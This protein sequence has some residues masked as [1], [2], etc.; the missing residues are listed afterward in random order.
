MEGSAGLAFRY[1]HRYVLT[2]SHPI[3]IVGAGVAGL[4]LAREL[5]QLGHHPV[6]LERSQGIGGRCATRRVDGQPVDHGVFFVHTQS[7]ALWR[8][9][10][11]VPATRREGWPG[12]IDGEGTACRPDAFAA[13]GRRVVFREGV[14]QFPK[15]LAAGLQVQTGVRVTAVAAPG[16]GTDAWVVRTAGGTSVQTPVLLFALP[17]PNVSDLLRTAEPLPPRVAGLLPLLGLVPSVPCLTVIA[18]YPA[19]TEAPSW[20]LS[21]PAGSSA[22]HAISHDSS[23][24]DGGAVLTLVLQAR[25]AWSRVWLERPEDAWARALL[26]EAASLLGPWAGQPASFQGHAWRKA[27]VAPGTELSQ[28]LLVELESG[29]RLGCAGDAFHPAGGV[30]GAYLSGLQLATRLHAVL[31]SRP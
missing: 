2:S 8:D 14:N 25:A 19:G 27:R 3:I 17:A 29:A 28:P 26:D 31:A 11:Q 18:R 30:E 13:Q 21:L 12:R 1:D 23:K 16:D 5:R 4:T 6:V 9:L 7:H 20:D 15:H 24:R 22:L 10:E